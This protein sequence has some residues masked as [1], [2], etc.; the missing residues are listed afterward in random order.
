MY[1]LKAQRNQFVHEVAQHSEIWT[2][3]AYFGK[4]AVYVNAD[5]SPFGRF[6]NWKTGSRPAMN[7]AR[8]CIKM[9]KSGDWFQSC[10]KKK[11]WTVCEKKATGSPSF[12]DT[13]EVSDFRKAKFFRRK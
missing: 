8:R 1:Q 10:C 3:A 13:N 9:D 2:G 4:N 5:Q 11:T 7:R 6:E 12:E